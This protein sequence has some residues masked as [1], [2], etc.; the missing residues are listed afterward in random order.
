M[1]QVRKVG[2]IIMNEYT[3]C[4]VAFLDILG[5]KKYIDKAECQEIYEV[6][7]E[8][9]N[10]KASPLVKEYPA[11]DNIKITIMSD[12]IIVYIDSS[13]TDAFLALTDVCSQ[14][15]IKLMN[16]AEPI[17]LRGGIAK[18]SLY[19]KD[20]IL[21]GKGLTSAYILENTLAVYPRIIFTETTRQ[22]GLKNVGKLY[23]FDYNQQF[24]HKD[25]DDLYFID[26]F[27]TFNYTKAY[28]PSSIEDVINFN[29]SYFEQ[30]HN[31]TNSMLSMEI[32]SSVRIKY[33]WLKKKYLQRIE[34]MP[35][36][37]KHFDILI[38]KEQENKDKLLNCFVYNDKNK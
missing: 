22:E 34:C 29:N 20:N 31:Y 28:S 1:R 4:F 15:Q 23:L 13:I 21:Y 35:E 3:E 10:F 12:S 36:V 16:R 37:K 30:I 32:S 26:Y 11:Y 14:M 25:E 8:I 6:F 24:Y 5:F 17:L 19:H 38:S 7:S 2:V 33:L 18:G 27:S 9:L